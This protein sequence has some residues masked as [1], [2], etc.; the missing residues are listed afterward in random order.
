[1]DLGDKA[2]LRYLRK[3]AMWLSGRATYSSRWNISTLDQS[4]LL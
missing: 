2:P 1:M 4:I 3:L